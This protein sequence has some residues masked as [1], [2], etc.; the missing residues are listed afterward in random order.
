[1]GLTEAQLE[2]AEGGLLHRRRL[3]E[4]ILFRG[5]EYRGSPDDPWY[6]GPMEV[7][8]PEGKDYLTVS[9]PDGDRYHVEDPGGPDESERIETVERRI[10][11]RWEDWLDAL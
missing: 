6:F 10:R 7:R 3:V 4:D 8:N 1:M 9:S 2:K 5:G 11:G